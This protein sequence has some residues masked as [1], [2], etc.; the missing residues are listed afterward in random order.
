MFSDAA[1]EF[2]DSGSGVG[3]GQQL[4]NAQEP[5]ND[6]ENILKNETNSIKNDPIAGKL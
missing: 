2:T 5:L 4:R 6:D 3:T 1:A